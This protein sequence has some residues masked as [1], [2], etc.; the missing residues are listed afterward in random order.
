MLADMDC[1]F[2]RPITFNE[3]GRFLPEDYRPSCATWWRWWRK[4]VKGIRLRTLVIGGRR[5]TTPAAV[6][7][8]I[9]QVTAA[10]NGDRPPA[11]TP[12]QRQ[13]AIEAAE[14]ELECDR[15]RKDGQE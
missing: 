11:R 4:G 14:R 2:E 7:D 10:S 8:F 1:D 6:Q 13:R 5:Y 9:T 12:R 3:A 15:K